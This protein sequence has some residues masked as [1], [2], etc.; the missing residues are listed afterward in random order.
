MSLNPLLP[1]NHFK[2][3]RIILPSCTDVSACIFSK[4]VGRNIRT[5][6]NTP[7]RHKNDYCQTMFNVLLH[8]FTKQFENEYSLW[9][10]IAIAKLILFA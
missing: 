10:V 2:R 8:I 5:Q 3:T 6:S 9:E 7:H 1:T 4:T